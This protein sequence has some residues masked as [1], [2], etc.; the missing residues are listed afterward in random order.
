MF[1]YI[2]VVKEERLLHSN[3]FIEFMPLEVISMS[4]TM[5]LLTLTVMCMKS[6]TVVKCHIIIYI[7]MFTNVTLHYSNVILFKKKKKTVSVVIR[8]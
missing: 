1:L 6:V 8:Y 4:I 2:I 7:S 3:I 5:P